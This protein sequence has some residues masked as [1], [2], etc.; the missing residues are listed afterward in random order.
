MAKLKIQ[1]NWNPTPVKGEENTEPSM[2][3]PDMALSINEILTRYAQGIGYDDMVKIGLYEGDE[4][5]IPNP[6]TL[7][8][9]DMEAMQM[10]IQDHISDLQAQAIK[11]VNDREIARE[12]ALKQRKQ[13]ELPIP[14]E[15]NEQKSSSDEKSF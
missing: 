15:K 8:L 10:Q 11:D 6:K 13:A 7:D 4:D 2:T 5:N 3:Q 14:D 12:N 9:A 1:T